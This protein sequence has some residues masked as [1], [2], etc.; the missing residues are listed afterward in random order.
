MLTLVSPTIARTQATDSS[1][2]TRTISANEEQNRSTKRPVCQGELERGRLR[3]TEGMGNLTRRTAAGLASTTTAMVLTAVFQLIYT[4]VMARLLTPSE[5]GLIA[6][7]NVAIGFTGRVSQ[8]GVGPALIQQP[9][10]DDTTIRSATSLAWLFGAVGTAIVIAL[11]PVAGWFF[12]ERAVVP[13]L[14][15]LAVSISMVAISLVPEALLRRGLRFRSLAT[16]DVVSFAVGYLGVGI[17]AARMGAGVWSL[18]AATLS[19]SVIRTLAIILV[20]RRGLRLGWSRHAV[21]RI[22]SFGS[23]VTAIGVVNNVTATLPTMFIGRVLGSGLL[24]Q[25]GRADMLI[26]LPIERLTST[27]SRVLFPALATVNLEPKRFL[28]GYSIAIAVAAAMI[29]PASSLTALLAAPLVAVVLGPG[30]EQ[31]ASVLPLLAATVA[32]GYLT[33]FAGV[34][35]E[36]LGRLRA[37]LVSEVAVG[38][39]L[40]AGMAVFV[41]RGL[42]WAVAVLV[43]AEM[44]RFS[45]QFA[46]LAQ[47]MRERV[48]VVLRPLRVGFLLALATI[49]AVLPVR[50]LSAN[51]PAIVSISAGVGASAVSLVAVRLLPP[52]AEL[53]R[54]LRQRY[55]LARLSSA[56]PTAPSSD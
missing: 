35:L 22:A 39:L 12:D 25:F 9:R 36:A 30:W 38:A 31:A 32:L 52:V 34:T 4:V 47:A 16:I 2:L 5:F 11:S 7:A 1:D 51:W 6:M 44:L 19:Q 37:K 42:V 54:E 41:R 56:E 26:R 14:M 3:V 48:T 24:G 23:Q 27:V 15:A 17:T 18:V 33:H 29:L 49:I 43:V 13:V 40:L 20:E 53:E 28:A 45:L 8:F 55:R 21:R 46:I 50:Y 10:I